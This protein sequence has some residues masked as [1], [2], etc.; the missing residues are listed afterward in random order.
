M[1]RHTNLNKS[2]TDST[3]ISN[4]IACNYS[5]NRRYSSYTTAIFFIAYSLLV[6]GLYLVVK[7]KAS[8]YKCIGSILVTKHNLKFKWSK[9][10]TWIIIVVDINKDSLKMFIFL[11]CTLTCQVHANCKPICLLELS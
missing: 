6:P 2:A 9:A 7:I 11:L 1:L 4:N 8:T 5:E 3:A 10:G